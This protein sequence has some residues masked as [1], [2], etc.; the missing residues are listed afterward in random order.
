MRLAVNLTYQGAAELAR[1]AEQLG[2]AAVLAPEGYRSDAASLLGMVAG[3]TERVA[4]ISGVMQIPARPPGLTALTAATLD[5]LSGGRFRLGLGVSNPDVAQGWY[6]AA[7]DRPLARTREYV[8]VVRRA[9]A[10]GAVRYEGRHYSVG[11]AAPLHVLTDPVRAD[12]PVYLAA[13]GPANLRLAGEIADGWIGVFTAPEAVAEAVKE[14]EGGRKRAGG[15]MA[16]FEV[17]PS[18]PTAVGP[19]PATAA[20]LLRDQYVYLMGIGDAE[21]NVYCALS[22]R[23][24]Y[25][26]VADALRERLA[27]GDRAGAARALPVDFID[28]T[29]LIGPVPRIAERMAEYAEAGVTTLGVMVSAAAATQAQRLAILRDCAEAWQLSGVAS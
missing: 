6:G 18:L 25:G 14:I 1:A 3:Q 16:G 26:H 8:E 23:L 5:A 29:A 9:L 24:G 12:L 2:Y 13:V 27:A 11:G 4:L 10:G 28:R 15:D 22:R 17:L 21:R 20:D 7:A 19:D